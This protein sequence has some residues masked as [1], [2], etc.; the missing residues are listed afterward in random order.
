M[1][2]L[3]LADFSFTRS[4]VFLRRRKSRLKSKAIRWALKRISC[5]AELENS[6]PPIIR[7]KLLIGIAPPKYASV[8]MILGES[9]LAPPFAN[10]ALHERVIAYALLLETEHFSALQL[11]HI[12][13][14]DIEPLLESYDWVSHAQI[15]SV[16]SDSARILKVAARIINPAQSGLIG[17]GYEGNSLQDEMPHYGSGKTIPRSLKASDFGETISVTAGASRIT[18]YG[19]AVDIDKIGIWFQRIC[20]LL[21]TNRR[22][23]FVSRFAEP[24]DFAATMPTL[25]PKL[26]VF[27]TLGFYARVRDEG[28]QLRRKFKKKG[29]RDTKRAGATEQMF[30]NV[31]SALRVNATLTQ[32]AFAI[33]T[34]AT[35]KTSLKID[36]S[37]LKNFTLYNGSKDVSL[38]AYINKKDLFSVYFDSPD[39]VY[40][41]ASL[42]R[43][44]GLLSEIDA[45]IAS[46]EGVAVL[47]AADREKVDLS[48]DNPHP[49]KSALTRFPSTSVF[50]IVE[51][52]F[53]AA[54]Y[55]F[56]D[57]LGDEWADHI[58]LN[59]NTKT[60]S[61]AHSKHGA[62]STR[63]SNLHEVVGQA[64]KNMGNLL[65][66]PS[67][68]A[69]KI[70]GFD[71]V[72]TGTLIRRIRKAPIGQD[73]RAVKGG[74]IASL[75]DN[76]LRREAVV[77]CSF[78]SQ[79]RVIQ[80]L[81]KLRAGTQGR[82][83]I[84]QLL[85]LLS[86]FVAASKELSIRPRIL[87]RP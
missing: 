33:G 42:F 46:L 75:T 5:L 18:S 55:I 22:S 57:D 87:C 68:L 21:S 7:Y 65:C 37:A 20:A 51:D 24:V 26:I 72:Y 80:E 48:R 28:L 31:I 38:S 50:S 67:A 79:A 61:F 39:Y 27:D 63:A 85:W 43:D 86:Y 76:G 64:L 62:P 77:C 32:G 58:V 12:G 41:G 16:F 9:V 83:H 78:L 1:Q 15:T 49:G 45:V 8:S 40:M 11:R 82:P 34:I 74:V 59:V 73:I 66:T 69:R 4:F 2:R 56:C 29:S 44:Q 81:E 60:L 36:L 53:V 52:Y 13:V 84:R 17:R 10:G 71:E 25:I 14:T 30:E 23:T 54:D 19:Q 70:D 3:N 47:S 6:A 35:T